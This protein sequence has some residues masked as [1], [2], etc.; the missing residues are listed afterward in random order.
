MKITKLR[1][2]TVNQILGDCPHTWACFNGADFNVSFGDANH[3]L[4]DKEKF[5]EM[6][7]CAG[8]KWDEDKINMEQTP[9]D[10]E[11]IKMYKRI[12]SLKK[13]VL[14]DLGS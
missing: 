3:T 7:D 6:L 12:D 9:L 1:T 4:V 2:V 14:I 11:M 10:F 13:N 5:E 8:I